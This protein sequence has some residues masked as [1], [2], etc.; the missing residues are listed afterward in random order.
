MKDQLV[1]FETAKL[2]KERGFTWKCMHGIHCSHFHFYEKKGMD[3]NIPFKD[4]FLPKPKDWNNYDD[5]IFH[6][7][8]PQVKKG[9]IRPYLSLPTQSLLLKWLRERHNLILII[10]MPTEGSTYYGYYIKNMNFP[11]YKTKYQKDLIDRK[12]VV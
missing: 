9:K 3:A 5:G 11:T 1:S 2:A 4:E 12:S 7:L 8:N 10:T 6:K